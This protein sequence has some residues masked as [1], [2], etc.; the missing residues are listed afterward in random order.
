VALQ[1]GAAV[2]AGTAAGETLL[3]D[4]FAVSQVR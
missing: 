3:L 2:K 4:Y 1:A